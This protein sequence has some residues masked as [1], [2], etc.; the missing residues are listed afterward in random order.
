M[1]TALS[2]N[3]GPCCKLEKGWT[4]VAQSVLMGGANFREGAIE[5]QDPSLIKRTLC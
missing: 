4:F 3:R 1:T 5:L 2:I